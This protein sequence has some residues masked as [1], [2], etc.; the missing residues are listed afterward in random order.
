MLGKQRVRKDRA[1]VGHAGPG[2]CRSAYQRAVSPVGSTISL[3]RP[4]TMSQPVP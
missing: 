3:N 4:S 2:L 1:A